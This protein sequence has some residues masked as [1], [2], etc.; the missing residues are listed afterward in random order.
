MAVIHFYANYQIPGQ[1]PFE[2]V[3]SMFSLF[4]EQNQIEILY[5]NFIPI[6]CDV[7]K[8]QINFIETIKVS[9]YYSHTIFA[10]PGI[11]D[12]IIRL[13]STMIAIAAKIRL[14]DELNQF[15]PRSIKNEIVREKIFRYDDVDSINKELNKIIKLQ[16]RDYAPKETHLQTALYEVLNSVSL[17][18]I[19]TKHDV[20]ELIT[21]IRMHSLASPKLGS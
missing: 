19:K 10:D 12:D 6:T 4:L 5:K 14:L 18:Q 7:T 13:L 17:D 9:P 15:D 20:D 11:K 21:S 8:G 1:Q 2:N 16:I 3:E